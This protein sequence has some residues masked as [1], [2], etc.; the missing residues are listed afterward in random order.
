MNKSLVSIIM[1][2]ILFHGNAQ[3][4]VVISEEVITQVGIKAPYIDAES[5]DFSWEIGNIEPSYR[6]PFLD[7]LQSKIFRGAI[8]IYHDKE[9][10]QPF[11]PEELYN[12]QY[13]RDTILVEDPETYELVEMVIISEANYNDA[14]ALQLCE[15]WEYNPKSLVIERKIKSYGV[16]VL[17]NDAENDFAGSLKKGQSPLFW[18]KNDPNVKSNE[19]I[20]LSPKIYYQIVLQN[21]SPEELALENSYS[22][23]I[24][25]PDQKAIESFALLVLQQLFEIPWTEADFENNDTYPYSLRSALL[26]FSQEFEGNS[27][28]LQKKEAANNYLIEHLPS[29]LSFTDKWYIDPISMSI[30]RKDIIMKIYLSDYSPDGIRMGFFPLILPSE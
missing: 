2:F 19:A 22:S 24:T 1:C 11:S 20:L 28:S 7:S 14:V 15:K 9:C 12:L 5:Y 6:I 8:V 13:K 4:T 26:E 18:I 16:L 10:L 21:I 27:T 29:M 23:T 3:N 30:I 25:A 17:N